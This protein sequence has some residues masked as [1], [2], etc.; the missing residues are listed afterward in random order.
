MTQYFSSSSSA[1]YLDYSNAT[2]RN[3]R[4]TGTLAGVKAPAYIKMGKSIRY[5]KA[6]LDTRLEQFNE[7][8]QTEKEA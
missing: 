3:A 1:N 6:T 7:L 4:H 8:E 5:D 2:L